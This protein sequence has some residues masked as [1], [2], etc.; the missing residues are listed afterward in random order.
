MTGWSCLITIKKL[1]IIL[2]FYTL[3][4]NSK[5]LNFVTLFTRAVSSNY[6]VILLNRDRG[7]ITIEYVLNKNK[8]AH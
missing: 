5:V 1:F 7:A 8:I 6:Y 3:Y 4:S 2:I